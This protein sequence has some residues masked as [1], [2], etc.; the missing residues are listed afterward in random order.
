M[1]LFGIQQ[2]DKLFDIAFAKKSDTTVV[3][4]GQAQ[5]PILSLKT[6]S[7]YLPK[8]NASDESAPQIEEKPEQKTKANEKKTEDKAT[9]SKASGKA[10]TAKTKTP[11]YKEDIEE[12]MKKLSPEGQK[13]RY[14]NLKASNGLTYKQA[15]EI[16]AKCK[17]ESGAANLK[18]DMF[19]HFDPRYS[20]YAIYKKEGVL[21]KIYFNERQYIID[22]LKSAEAVLEF[23]KAVAAYKEIREAIA[24]EH[25]G[26]VWDFDFSNPGHIIV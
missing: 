14:N 16:I 21:D 15:K 6:D 18:L 3:W 5:Q 11:I 23:K 19:W 2:S 7:D 9:T 25:D 4:G 20:K 1:G 26:F 8:F 24:S 13:E 17:N 12:T 22:N 10:K